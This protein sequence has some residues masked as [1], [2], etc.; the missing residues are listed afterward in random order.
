[1]VKETAV[2]L[3]QQP[4]PSPPLHADKNRK[5]TIKAP[6]NLYLMNSI[7]SPENS[8]VF[9]VTFQFIFNGQKDKNSQKYPNEQ[10]STQLIKARI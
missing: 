6:V 3:F 9:S 2:E 7:T 1:M 8:Y 5:A 10:N 4:L